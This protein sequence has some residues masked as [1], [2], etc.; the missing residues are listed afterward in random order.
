MQEYV[1]Q[2]STMMMTGEENRGNQDE[3]FEEFLQTVHFEENPMLLDDEL[4]DDF[5]DWVGNLAPDDILYYANQYS[6]ERNAEVIAKDFC[7]D[8][9][10]ED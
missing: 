4:S 9:G 10:I 2:M 1:N 7:K 3:S 8:N 6:P 5:S